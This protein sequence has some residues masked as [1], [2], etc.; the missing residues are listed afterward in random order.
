MVKLIESTGELGDWCVFKDSKGWW[1]FGT[2]TRTGPLPYSRGY[3]TRWGALRGL[4]DYLKDNSKISY[5]K[6]DKSSRT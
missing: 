2:V 6:L 4:K 3:F 1:H 5:F